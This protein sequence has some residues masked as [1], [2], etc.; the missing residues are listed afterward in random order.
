MPEEDNTRQPEVETMWDN[1]KMRLAAF[2][3]GR[4]G[5]DELGLTCLI[6]GVVLDIL[7]RLTGWTLLVFVG[8]ALFVW[9]LYRMLS[10]DQQ[11]RSDENE[12]FRA[13]FGKTKTEG[14]QFVNRVKNSKEYKY[15]RCPGCKTRLRLKRG[16]GDRHI[17]CPKCGREF[18]QKA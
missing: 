8:M 3:A 13:L 1:L 11:R 7:G 5:A 17:K 10:R 4:Y 2:M 18:D 9:T 12:K 6:A 16:S 14:K 15:F